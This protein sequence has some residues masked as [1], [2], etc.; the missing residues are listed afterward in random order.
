MDK[1]KKLMSNTAIFAIGQFGTKLLSF[2]L[3]RLYTAVLS[4]PEYSTADLLYNTINVLVPIVTFCMGDAIIRFGL[5]KAYDKK[6]IYSSALFLTIAGMTVF[7]VTTPV[8]NATSFYGGYTMLLYCYCYFSCF[9][10]LAS[11]YVRARG[12]VKLYAVDG[13]VVTLIQFICNLIFM[14]WLKMGITGYI[15]SFIVSDA[16]SFAFLTFFGGL[17]KSMDTKFIDKKLIKELLRYS[18]PLIPAYLLWWITAASDR[19]FVIKMVSEEANGLYSFSSRIPALLMMVTTLFYQAWQVSSIEERDSSSLGSF[20]RSVY[21]VYTS[22]MFVGAAG[23]IM[24]VRP[25]TMLFAGSDEYLGAE[26]YTVILVIA[27]VF[28]CFCQ[29]L[30]SIYSVKKKSRNSCLTALVAAVTNLILNFI[31][32]PKIGVYGAAIATAISYFACFAVRIFDTRR[33]ISFKV[34]YLRTILNTVMLS[35]MC[36]ITIKSP[37]LYVLWII[38]CFA[39]VLILNSGAVIKTLKKILNRR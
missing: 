30:S 36:V 29:F 24:I 11:N 21:N 1:Y 17:H 23:I 9:R 22:L 18:L 8:W 3:L 25:L 10:Q 2:F 34:D 12:Q 32:I 37:K 14:L 13:I 38:L 19:L 7:A 35:V 33:F 15:I 20:Y 4:K 16:L 39:A 6:K 27:M 5:D 31:L 26:K 28:Q